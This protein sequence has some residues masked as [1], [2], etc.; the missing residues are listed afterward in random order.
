MRKII[1]RLFGLREL[2]EK[3]QIDLAKKLN[4]M[5]SDSP[6]SLFGMAFN[7]VTFCI[8]SMDLYDNAWR[9]W[10]R[11]LGCQIPDEQIRKENGE[12][13]ILLQRALFV[14][15]LSSIEFV[16]KLSFLNSPSLFDERDKELYTRTANPER[17]Y[18]RGIIKKSHQKGLI[19]KEDK[20]LW[21]GLINFRNS[22]VHNN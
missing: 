16:F 8:E 13:I 11:P 15:M 20:D 9:T 2:C 10:K 14:E 7:K 17:L 19:N 3:T 12:R 4:I 5:E 22:I 18:L 1:E 6:A 21:N